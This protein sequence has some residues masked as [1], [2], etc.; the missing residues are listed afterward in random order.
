MGSHGGPHYTA[1]TDALLTWYVAHRR[2]LPWRRTV[3]PYRIWVSEVMLQQTQVSTVLSYYERFLRRFPTV[4]GLAV[5]ELDEVLALWQGL[6][7]YARAR[8]LHAA[9][10][11]VCG[12]HGGQL[13]ATQVEMLALPGVGEYTAGAVLSI[14][15]GLDIPAVDGNVVRALCRLFDYAEDPSE[16][17][18]KKALRGYAQALLPRGRAGDFNQAMMELGSTLCVRREPSCPECPVR[19]FCRARALGVQASRPVTKQR[20]RV[21]HREFVAALAERADKLL[22]VRRLPRGLLGGLWEMPSG[23]V[24]DGE[25]S[26]RGLIRHLRENLGLG[27]EVG[28][29]LVDAKHAYSHFRITVHVYRCTVHGEPRPAN[30]WDRYHWMSPV[31]TGRYGLTGVTTKILGRLPWPTPRA[32]L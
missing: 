12:K 18:G 27:C 31:E 29:H 26:A 11:V 17:A 20:A 3:D 2:D 6:G 15:F 8:N 13:P 7:Y 23:E 28:P 4:S 22:I 5:A 24:L 30:L 1:I 21:P 16:A 10:S 9:A 14:A 19:S 32:S 25:D